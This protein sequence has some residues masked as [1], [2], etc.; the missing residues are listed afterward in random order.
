MKRKQKQGSIILT[1]F[2]AF[3]LAFLAVPARADQSASTAAPAQKIQVAADPA[4]PVIDT[5][6]RQLDA[7]HARNSE[8][9]FS[10]MSPRY[11]EKFRNAERFMVQIRFVYEP[12][13]NHEN[14][15]VTSRQN[16]S[17]AEILKLEMKDHY[18]D[19][20]QVI[21]GLRQ[22]QDGRWLIDSFTVLGDDS[23]Q[24]I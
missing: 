16:V 6:R 1:A 15:K 3:G 8:A 18:G 10:L 20:A 7:I 9:A 23:A 21:Y 12:I 13:Y 22:Q 24:P 4:D 14:F 19:P 11:H 17:G 2:L 5:I